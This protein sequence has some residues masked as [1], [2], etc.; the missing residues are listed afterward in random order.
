M[1]KK[2][3]SLFI[4]EIEE[5][6]S[7]QLKQ[8][9]VTR[10]RTFTPRP[11]TSVPQENTENIAVA[12]GK[13]TE[14]FMQILFGAMEKQNIEGFDYMEFKNS[15]KSLKNMPNMDEVTRYKSAYAMAQTMGATPNSLVSTAEH[16]LNVLSSEEAKFQSALTSN[17]KRQI[18]S[19]QQEMQKLADTVKAKEQHIQ[20]LQAEIS[21]HKEAYNTLS[22]EIQG[23]K[24]KI[25]GTKA[26]FEMSYNAI[27]L[28]IQ[29]DIERIK[30]YLA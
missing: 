28:Q 2:L 22:T 1:L 29:K 11:N 12:E 4:E 3:K 5:E 15:L 8:Q 13:V 16:Y 23:A 9:S 30:T 19:K 27:R 17:S 14:K 10:K 24:N 20:K 26:N 7:K 18:G 6:Q 25:A 21:K